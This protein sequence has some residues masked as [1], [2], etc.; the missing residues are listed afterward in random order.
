ML[1]IYKDL[2]IE[3]Y[4]GD[5]SSISRSSIME[6]KKSP[7]HYWNAYLNPNRPKKEPSDAMNFG[8]AFHTLVLEPQLF[9]DQFIIAPEKVLL[10][11]VGRDRYESYKSELDKV[12]MGSLGKTLLSAKQ[13]D[14][15]NYMRDSV[16]KHEQASRILKDAEVEQSLFWIDEHTGIKCKIRPD[17][18][19]A[20]IIADLKTTDDASESSFQRAMVDYGY[21]VQ[22][23]MIREG[24]REVIG[25]DMKNIVFIAVEKKF[26]YSTV[27][28]I[29]DDIALEYGL[30]EFKNQL[31]KL[32]SCRESN[33]WESYE[34]KVISL[35]NWALLR[36]VS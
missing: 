26:P 11:D 33:I 2:S 18:W 36:G 10:K 4:H 12:E 6:L 24:V 34:N 9:D 16:L 31:L 13:Y 22:A 29:I 21:H 30:I 27:T 14:T 32:K 3:E 20:S 35:P 15:L 17:I 1:G 7:W 5:A 23:A 25:Y 28:Y 8:S 19:Q